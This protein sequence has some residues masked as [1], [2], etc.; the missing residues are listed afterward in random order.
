M[1]SWVQDLLGAHVT[2]NQKRKMF[3]RFIFLKD[4]FPE[5]FC[6]AKDKDA[7][8]ADYMQIRNDLVHGAMNFVRI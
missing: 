8:M 6:I 3:S 7:S 4:S 1:R 2:T 5:L